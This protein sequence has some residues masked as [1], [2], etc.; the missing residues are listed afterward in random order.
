MSKKLRLL[1]WQYKISDQHQNSDKT[2]TEE[3]HFVVYADVAGASMN[4][5]ENLMIH[6]KIS[7][8]LCKPNSSTI[9]QEKITPSNSSVGLTK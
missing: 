6:N 3:R 5:E 2:P 4:V 9:R 7:A 1:C 8:E